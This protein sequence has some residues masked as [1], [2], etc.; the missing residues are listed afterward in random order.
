MKR[1]GI[2][3]GTFNPIHNG[4][5]SLV[6]QV[7]E[8]MR[9]DQVFIIPTH[10]PPHKK[11][12]II[13]GNQDRLNM[14]RLAFENDQNIMV[15][16]TE[17]RRHEISYTYKT[18][19]ILKEKY[20]D[21]QWF[22]IIG[23][24]MLYTLP[25][26]K[27]A[28]YILQNCRVLAAARTPNSFHEMQAFVESTKILSKKVQVIPI[29]IYMMS[30][31]K[32]RMMLY[33][34]LNVASYLP[35]NILDYL[36]DKQIYP[37]SYHALFDEIKEILKKQLS[38]QRYHHTLC[39]AKEAKHLAKQYGEHM[40]KA[41]LAGLLH[42]CMKCCSYPNLLQYLKK[43]DILLSYIDKKIPANFHAVAGASYIKN[44]LGILDQKVI[45]AVR[46]HTTAK[47]HM[48]VFE[49]ILYV[50]DAISADRRGKNIENIRKAAG[51]SLDSAMLLILKDNFQN[52][53]SWK[54]VI[55]P[56]SL[57]AYNELICL[58]SEEN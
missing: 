36:K 13:A 30:S 14:C 3:G 35:P 12:H 8:K 7:R 37:V 6:R 46:Y 56:L 54:K 50:A 52:L 40:Q 47:S 26:W 38:A 41:Y 57:Q 51:Q 33:Q 48:S 53:L 20:P 15:D 16:S 21:N 9:L 32:I 58:T 17:I 5:I 44:E 24:D 31:T 55:H 1:I 2:Y 28:E 45:R 43:N 27:R 10:L 49:K 11:I 42:D 18:I 29:D 4:H 34:D 39:V 22:L 23:G 25:H 19:E